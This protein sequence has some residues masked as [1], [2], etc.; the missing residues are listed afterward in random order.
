M[1]RSKSKTPSD[2]RKSSS[3]K[4]K[5]DKKEKHKSS[6]HKEHHHHHKSSKKEKEKK[7]SE[8]GGKVEIPADINPNYKPSK[9]RNHWP[10]PTMDNELPSS[11]SRMNGNTPKLADNGWIPKTTQSKTK[12]FSGR[13]TSAFSRDEKFPSLTDL[14][15][16]VLQ[17]NVRHIYECGDIPFYV[18]KPVMERAK[19]E[20]LMRIEEYNQYLVTETGQSSFHSKNSSI[21][22]IHKLNSAKPSQFDELFSHCTI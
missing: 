20:D 21:C 3:S 1:S 17:D 4:H 10:M 13:K 6:H 12:V 18:L 16:H 22:A 7:E 15:I 14:C 11:S 19:A 9:I 2:E 5:K 8:N